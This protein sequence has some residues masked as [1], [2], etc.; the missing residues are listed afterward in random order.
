MLNYLPS[1]VFYNIICSVQPRR[2]AVVGR[3]ENRVRITDGTAAVYG[4]ELSLA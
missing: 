3:I 2:L 4:L 1:T